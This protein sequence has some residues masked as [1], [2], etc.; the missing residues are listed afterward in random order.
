MES[1][2]VITKS[3]EELCEEFGV[4][5]TGGFLS[6]N[7]MINIPS[8]MFQIM[9]KKILVE[10]YEYLYYTTEK[11]NIYRQCDGNKWLI[12]PEWTKP[13]NNIIEEAFD[14]ILKSIC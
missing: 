11:I 6:L 1:F 8:L 14:D 12:L 13:Y 9:G 10:K 7:T 3:I 5:V 4:K 2:Y